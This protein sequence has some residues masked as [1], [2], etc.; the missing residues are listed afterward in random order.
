MNKLKKSNIIASTFI[1][2]VIMIV[3]IIISFW[4][5]IFQK[6]NPIPYIKAILQ[7]NSNHTYVQVQE[8]NSNIFITKRDKI[9]EFLEYIEVKYEVSFQ[10][11]MGSG[12]ILSSNEKEVIA[13]SEIYLK[14]YIVW[15]L[16]VEGR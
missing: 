4:P 2:I 6:G 14:Y 1:V 12:Y 7:L 5:V 11:Q 13:S 16:N 15:N 10:E 3:I 9:E 8:N